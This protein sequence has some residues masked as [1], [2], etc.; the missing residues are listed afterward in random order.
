[1]GKKKALSLKILYDFLWD[2]FP[3]FDFVAAEGICVSQTQVMLGLFSLN[4]QSPW[5]R[6]WK[7]HLL[8]HV[9]IK[10]LLIAKNG[11]CAK[12]LSR[13]SIIFALIPRL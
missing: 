8:V 1:M 7:I 13:Q 9:F 11:L 5:H 12:K 3:Y 4:R 6:E 10:T 2:F